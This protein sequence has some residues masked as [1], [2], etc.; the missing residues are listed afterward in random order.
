[1]PFVVVHVHLHTLAMLPRHDAMIGGDH[2]LDVHDDGVPSSYTLAIVLDRSD[3][4]DMHADGW[5]S[6]SL[7]TYPTH[8]SIPH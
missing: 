3:D 7:L 6:A 2:E 4:V 5:L 8:L 1:M